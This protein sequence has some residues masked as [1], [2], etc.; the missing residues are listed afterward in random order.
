M[1][2][3]IRSNRANI[4]TS[5]RAVCAHF[6]SYVYGG[7]VVV[8]ARTVITI[9]AISD[10]ASQTVD[11]EQRKSGGRQNRNDHANTYYLSFAYKRN[12]IR[13]MESVERRGDDR[14]YGEL[15]CESK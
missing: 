13:E 6:V 10:S 2:A 9:Q 15:S 12:R 14:R 1:R 3:H 8:S 4:V 5:V 11:G 7:V